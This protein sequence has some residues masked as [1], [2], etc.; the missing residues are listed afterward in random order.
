MA[1]YSLLTRPAIPTSPKKDIEA[2]RAG[3]SLVDFGG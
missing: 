3:P 1:A 2:A